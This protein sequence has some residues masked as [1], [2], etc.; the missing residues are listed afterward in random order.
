MYKRRLWK[1]RNNS[2]HGEDPETVAIALCIQVHRVLAQLYS[3]RSEIMPRDKDLFYPTVADHIEAHPGT[4]V[5]RNWLST[6]RTLI[7]ASAKEALSRSLQGY[8]PIA[9]KRN[10]RP[11]DT[12][13]AS[14]STGTFRV[15]IAPGA[16]GTP[17]YRRNRLIF[18]FIPAPMAPGN[19]GL[20][21]LFGSR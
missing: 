19:A 21:H 18:Y 5:I 16:S 12:T 9:H 10:Y 3:F 20:F 7:V 8:F 15:T 6:N 1:L 2:R 17:C 14:I 4:T 13:R 11:A